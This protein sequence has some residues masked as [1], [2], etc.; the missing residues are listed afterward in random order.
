M[1]ASVQKL[2]NLIMPFVVIL[3]CLIP[4]QLI[5]LQHFSLFTTHRQIS[6]GKRSP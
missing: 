4:C 1:S 6:Y 3:F 5:D 2:E